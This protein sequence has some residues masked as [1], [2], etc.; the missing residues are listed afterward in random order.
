VRA[1]FL[2]GLISTAAGCD[3]GSSG[4]HC[5]SSCDL[6]SGMSNDDLA[7]SGAGCAA[8]DLACASNCGPPADLACASNCGPPIDMAMSCGTSTCG[9]GAVDT[10]SSAAHC[11]ACGHDCRGGACAGGVCQGV[12]I[13][14]T[15][16]QPWGIAVDAS[17]IYWTNS[18][19]PNPNATVMTMAKTGTTAT[20]IATG[21]WQPRQIVVTASA[22]Y[23]ENT[24]AG[25]LWRAAP[26]L[27]GTPAA[28]VTEPSQMQ[29]FAV[30]GA[31]IYFVESGSSIIRKAPLT[32]T[33]TVTPLTTAQAGQ[34][35]GSLASDGTNVYWVNSMN[36]S[37]LK[38]SV[39]GGANSPVAAPAHPAGLVVLVGTN[40]Y[41]TT[42]V[43]I[44]V[45]ATTGGAAAPVVSGLAQ[46]P[47]GLA[48]DAT[49]VYWTDTS[50]GSV[51]RAS[52][53]DGV[54]QRIASGAN[55]PLGIAVDATTIYWTVYGT[56]GTMDGAIMR[57]VK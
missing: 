17:N 25:E 35:P 40:L 15:Q 8:A 1:L 34:V 43:D 14:M 45:I 20:S 9:G 13:A 30:D 33:A 26:P 53:A 3:N 29:E 55:G 39:N 6:A 5:T 46:P 51:W 7:C 23:W 22:L 11:G 2:L 42:S 47:S 21:Q 4:G 57:A 49:G 28:F 38:T 32:G 37:I 50:L 41:F 52:L 16:A 10:C 12:Q 18:T 36:G 48:A 54:P 24:L 31:N 27:S 44:E 56:P 19:G